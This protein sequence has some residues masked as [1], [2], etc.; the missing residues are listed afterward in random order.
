[1]GLRSGTENVAGVIGFAEAL[2]LVESRRKNE[3]K[4][5]SKLKTNLQKSN[6][7]HG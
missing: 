5:L 7:L 3:A 4:R 2:D 6:H 1:M